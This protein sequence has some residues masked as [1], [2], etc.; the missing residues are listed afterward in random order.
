MLLARNPWRLWR[1][2]AGG[3]V[4]TGIDEIFVRPLLPAKL[5]MSLRSILGG[6]P[7]ATAKVSASAEA[8]H[9][10]DLEMDLATYRVRRQGRDIH[11]S[12]IAFRILRRL[13]KNPEQVVTREQLK[14]ARVAGQ[15]AGGTQNHRRSCRSAATGPAERLR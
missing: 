2:A 10:A 6:L 3:R 11:L 14:T 1:Y 13:L 15:G 12:S 9:Y 5:V 7:S 4:K 8:V